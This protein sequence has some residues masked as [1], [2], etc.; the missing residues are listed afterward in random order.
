MQ[1]LLRCFC[2]V[3]IGYHISN[4]DSCTISNVQNDSDL[5]L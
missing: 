1:K 2:G 4:Y 5:I 3:N